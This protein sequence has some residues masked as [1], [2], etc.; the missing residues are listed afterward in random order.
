MKT[1][2]YPGILTLFFL[3]GCASIG[4]ET[5]DRDRP[6]KV[7]FTFLMILFRL[8]DTGGGLQA[9]LITVRVG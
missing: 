7:T 4:P 3:A 2:G 5:I 9:P 6:S 1:D 8:V